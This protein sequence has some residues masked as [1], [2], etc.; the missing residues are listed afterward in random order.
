MAAG[1]ALEWLFPKVFAETDRV[2]KATVAAQSAA[3][4]EVPT[5]VVW[6][7]PM[8]VLIPS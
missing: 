2:Y 6:S 5:P 4:S 7:T 3:Q 1:R 8:F